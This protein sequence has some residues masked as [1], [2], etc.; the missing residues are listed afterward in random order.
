MILLLL[1][2][3]N[4]GT[5]RPA[6]FPVNF[7]V[8]LISSV[9]CG[10]LRNNIK[11]DGIAHP[12]ESNYST[13]WCCLKMSI[14]S[15]VQTCI[16]HAR[17]LSLP[18]VLEGSWQKGFFKRRKKDFSDQKSITRMQ[19]RHQNRSFIKSCH[20]SKDIIQ[21]APLSNTL[22]QPFIKLQTEAL[23]TIYNQEI[24]DSFSLPTI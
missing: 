2:P 5:I 23:L 21:H 10:S 9:L 22:L 6:Q 12:S 11:V 3:S 20:L 4:R 16:L 18:I 1:I 8:S 14:C 17:R 19:K 7:S 13:Y 15:T 24:L